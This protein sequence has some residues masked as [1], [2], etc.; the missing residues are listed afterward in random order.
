VKYSKKTR[1]GAAL[2]CAIAAS[3]PQFRNVLRDVAVSLG[4]QVDNSLAERPLLLACKAWWHPTS[5]HLS[6]DNE[7]ERSERS[8]RS[9][10]LIRTGWTP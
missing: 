8:A 5:A 6:L 7:R 9:E 10:A 4:I 2:I 3:T 1:E